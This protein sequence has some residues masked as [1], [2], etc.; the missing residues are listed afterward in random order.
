MRFRWGHLAPRYLWH[1]ISIKAN[2]RPFGHAHACNAFALYEYAV[3]EP[4]LV[5]A[6]SGGP[7]PAP[8]PALL[9][10]LIRGG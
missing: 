2:E 6:G 1:I 10:V 8:M 7:P 9:G 3:S 5:S 4:M